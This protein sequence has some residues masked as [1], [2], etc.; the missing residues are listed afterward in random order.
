MALP[1][2]C[3]ISAW[4]LASPLS[5]SRTVGGSSVALTAL[6]KAPVAVSSA[7]PCGRSEPIET[8]RLRLLRLI[9]ETPSE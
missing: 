8:T 2:L 4:I 1:K 5:A 7:T 6:R 3:C 9:E